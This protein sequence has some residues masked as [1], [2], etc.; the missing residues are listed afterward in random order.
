MSEPVFMK[1]GMY[2]TAPELISRSYLINS[3][4]HF[5]CL[6]VYFPYRC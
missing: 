5:Q 3:S 2:I 1:L 4:H 6:Y